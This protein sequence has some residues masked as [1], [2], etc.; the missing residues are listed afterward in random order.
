MLRSNLCPV[1]DD[2]LNSR[3]RAPLD[4]F[5]RNTILPV[6]QGSRWGAVN[7]ENKLIVPPEWEQM[8]TFL[9]C[10]DGQQFA[11]V[12]IDHQAALIDERGKVVVDPKGF[13]GSH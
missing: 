13:V 4:Y 7:L 1:W 10:D 8:S 2:V 12:A 11:N 6:K 5:S 9:Q 3:T